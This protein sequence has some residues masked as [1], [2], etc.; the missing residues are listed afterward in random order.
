MNTLT[1]VEA[2]VTSLFYTQLAYL[3]LKQGFFLPYMIAVRLAVYVFV[4][5]N[6][7]KNMQYCE[8]KLPGA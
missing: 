4:L 8:L 6:T 5:L 7:E 2:S 1:N 3:I